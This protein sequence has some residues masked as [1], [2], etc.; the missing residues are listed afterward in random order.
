MNLWPAAALEAQAIAARSYA[1]A[2]VQARVGQFWNLDAAFSRDMAYDPIL[3]PYRKHARQL[4][5]RVANY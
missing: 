4:S 5:P 3:V 1:S 2:Q